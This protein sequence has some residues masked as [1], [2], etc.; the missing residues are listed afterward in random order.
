[1]TTQ[2]TS[3]TST[4]KAFHE[5]SLE[6]SP[7]SYPLQKDYTTT[8][9][10]T[11]DVNTLSEGLDQVSISDT[12]G[13]YRP[14][15]ASYGMQASYSGQDAYGESSSSTKYPLSASST[16]YSQYPSSNYSD[17]ALTAPAQPSE[18]ISSQNSGLQWFW[19]PE[20]TGATGRQPPT[21]SERAAARYQ[22]MSESSNQPPPG[23]WPKR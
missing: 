5:P 19:Q 15:V 17:L 7:E 14:S 18:Y 9:A 11:A 13:D 4:T 16:G 21:R 8:P 23:G 6:P 10:I 12:S 1:M 20:A 22:S 3:S 2:E